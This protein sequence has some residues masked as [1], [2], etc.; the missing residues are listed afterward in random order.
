MK[1]HPGL[2]HEQP[3]YSQ[4]YEDGYDHA[5]RDIENRLDSLERVNLKEDEYDEI[6]CD[7]V[8]YDDVINIIDGMVEVE[9]R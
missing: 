3:E 1:I 8:A 6:G 9:K 7:H 2:K 5:L 4:G